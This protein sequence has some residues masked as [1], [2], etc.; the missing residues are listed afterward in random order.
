MLFSCQDMP[1]SAHAEQEDLHTPF[2]PLVAA[3]MLRSRDQVVYKCA[4]GIRG[5]AEL[6]EREML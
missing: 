6:F 1:T 4:V 5:F 2:W 3:M